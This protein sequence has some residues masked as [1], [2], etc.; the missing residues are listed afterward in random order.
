MRRIQLDSSLVGTVVEG[1]FTITQ[2]LGAGAMGATYRARQMSLDRD[3]CIKFLSLSSLSEAENVRRFKREARIL[4]RLKHKNIVEC[5]SFGIFDHVYPYLVMEL[6]VGESLRQSLANGAIEWSRACR[7]VVQA[8]DALSYAHA[9]GIIHRDVKPDNM[10]ICVD[11]NS[12][13]VKLIDF[14]LAGKLESV[15]GVDTLTAPGTTLGTPNY[16]PPEAFSGECGIAGDIY[17]LGCVLHECVSGE[18]PFAAE[19]PVAV[20]SNQLTEFLP[21]LPRSVRPDEVRISLDNIVKKATE[22]QPPDRFASCGHLSR[23]LRQIEDSPHLIVE[24]TGPS[25]SRR[26][27]GLAVIVV[28]CVVLLTATA[29]CISK[30]VLQNSSSTID[31][32]VFS[33]VVSKLSLMNVSRKP[34][35]EPAAVQAELLALTEEARALRGPWSSISVKADKEGLVVRTHSFCK[36]LREFLYY[37]GQFLD[38]QPDL[39][40]PVCSLCFALTELAQALPEVATGFR[41]MLFDL[42]CDLLMSFGCYLGAGEMLETRAPLR[43]SFTIE[44]NPVETLVRLHRKLGKEMTAD[45]VFW[46]SRRLRPAVHQYELLPEGR[47]LFLEFLHWYRLACEQSGAT[48]FYEYSLFATAKALKFKDKVLARRA[49]SDIIETEANMGRVEQGRLGMEGLLRN[50]QPNQY[51]VLEVARQMIKLNWQERAARLLL[52]ARDHARM[53]NDSSTWCEMESHRLVAL[54][55]FSPNIVQETSSFLQSSIWRNAKS[56]WSVFSSVFNNLLAAAY[57]SEKSRGKD[58][59]LKLLVQCQTLLLDEEP[60]SFPDL[61]KMSGARRTAVPTVAHYGYLLYQL[62]QSFS[63]VKA[64]KESLTARQRFLQFMEKHEDSFPDGF[65][66]FAARLELAH[67]FQ[68]GDRQRE[69]AALVSWCEKDMTHL[70]KNCKTAGWQNWFSVQ[71]S[72]LREAGFDALADRMMKERTRRP[73]TQW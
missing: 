60:Q 14:G 52:D 9:Q 38:Q 36:S 56:N 18:R 16:M 19:T 1:D 22:K 70:M 33:E 31:S 17:A 2:F 72:W 43:K 4:A 8:T 37:H 46:L 67:A 71:E 26:R 40:S 10:M 30:G 64:Y 15:V 20:M 59:A 57:K 34:P 12:E 11:G 42:Q 29:V 62:I 58:D 32:D 5:Y 35:I 28:A 25:P 6:I 39:K 48:D 69:A 50:Y 51:D 23:V 21:P 3:V 53:R 45:G 24:M 41:Y 63:Q 13:T 47:E 61:S 68:G 44:Q 55:A 27:P 65:F 49:L 54:A 7:I 73:L 66:P